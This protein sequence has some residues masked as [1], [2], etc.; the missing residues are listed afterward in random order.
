MPCWSRP[1][2]VLSTEV[3]DGPSLCTYEPLGQKHDY[4]DVD[5]LTPREL[6]KPPSAYGVIVSPRGLSSGGSFLCGCA[7]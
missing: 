3:D 4:A 2:N 6:D 5:M 1:I 7:F